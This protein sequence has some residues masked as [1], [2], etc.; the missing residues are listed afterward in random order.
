MNP[1]S[2]PC[3]RRSQRRTSKQAETIGRAKLVYGVRSR[4][5]A[6]G[7]CCRFDAEVGGTMQ[8]P[9]AKLTQYGR[10]TR[11]QGRATVNY[12]RDSRAA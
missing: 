11:P 6:R 3:A 7:V 8:E 9:S 2:R 4:G 1:T 12:R 5:G 10:L